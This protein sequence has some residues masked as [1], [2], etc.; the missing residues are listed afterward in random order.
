[1]FE[2]KKMPRLRIGRISSNLKKKKI[3]LSCRNLQIKK[4]SEKF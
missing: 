3:Y 4:I 1:M 2:I